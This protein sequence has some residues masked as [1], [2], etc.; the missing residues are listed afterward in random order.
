VRFWGGRNKKGAEPISAIQIK[1]FGVLRRPSHMLVGSG[2]L[3]TAPALSFR[4]LQD[5]GFLSEELLK[6]TLA[7]RAKLVNGL[8]FHKAAHKLISSLGG[9]N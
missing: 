5:S 9:A 4:F 6:R 1:Q 7:S 3:N 8:C 2:G